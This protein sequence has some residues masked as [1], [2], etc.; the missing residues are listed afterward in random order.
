M[1]SRIDVVLVGIL[2]LSL[3]ACASVE[4]GSAF[5]KGSRL[6]CPGDSRKCFID[7]KVDRQNASECSIRPLDDVDVGHPKGGPVSDDA[8]RIRAVWVIK[9]P[10]FFVPRKIFRFAP[11]GIEATPA[12]MVNEFA[13]E[14]LD[15][16]ATQDEK[17]RRFKWKSFHPSSPKPAGVKYTVNVQM[18]TGGD[19]ANPIVACKLDPI[20]TN[21]TDALAP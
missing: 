13:S 1:N 9:A 10:H 14:G 7:V 6:H 12:D 15:D 21:H 18:Q 2:M 20:I 4:S 8:K 11:N 3:V 19:W 16:E 5:A 17:P